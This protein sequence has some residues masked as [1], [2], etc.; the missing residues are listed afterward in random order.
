M[1]DSSV[2]EE[3]CGSSARVVVGARDASSDP[4]DGLN[5]GMDVTS[6]D[7]LVGQWVGVATVGH[8]VGSPGRGVGASVGWSVGCSVGCGVRRTGAAVGVSASSVGVS[9]EYSVLRVGDGV[10]GPN[11]IVGMA[12]T[13]GMVGPWDGASVGT[14]VGEVGSAVG[15]VDGVPVVGAGDAN[16]ERRVGCGTEPSE[17]VGL[18]VQN[19]V[20]RVGD[21]VGLR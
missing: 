6:N 20:L 5:E 10:V 15:G 2:G 18:A 4:A 1:T 9:V 13:D 19:S 12:G 17:L 8:R 21:A 16:S 3:T 11:T 14:G 7:D